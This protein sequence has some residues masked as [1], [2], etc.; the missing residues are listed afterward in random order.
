VDTKT[1][2]KNCGACGQICDGGEC[3]N[4]KCS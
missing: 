3:K 2:K 4:G 1:D